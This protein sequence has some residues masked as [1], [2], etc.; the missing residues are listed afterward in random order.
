MNSK[1]SIGAIYIEDC[2]L[3]LATARQA[4]A[5][6]GNGGQRCRK[7]SSLLHVRLRLAFI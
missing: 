2:G 7:S 5:A 1:G 4:K 6:L 3:Q